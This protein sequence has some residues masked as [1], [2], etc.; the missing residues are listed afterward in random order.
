VDHVA[1]I[2]CDETAAGCANQQPVERDDHR[3]VL[4]GVLKPGR[5]IGAVRTADTGS[6]GDFPLVVGEDVTGVAQIA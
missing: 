3:D 6:T 2:R 1:A 5:E 4:G